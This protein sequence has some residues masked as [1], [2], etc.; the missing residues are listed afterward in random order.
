[1]PV[2]LTRRATVGLLASVLLFGGQ[3]QL[4][5]E[6]SNDRLKQWSALPQGS[7]GLV[8]IIDAHIA[9][10]ALAADK[11]P[12]ATAKW[13]RDLPFVRQYRLAPGPYFIRLPAAPLDGVAV[14]AKEGT[15][16]YVLLAAESVPSISGS[17]PGTVIRIEA[18]SGA[19]PAYVGKWLEKAYLSGFTEAYETIFL[20]NPGKVLLVSTEP[21]WSAPPP[22]PPPKN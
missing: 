5:A 9:S 8:F 2:S 7:S 20:D 10:F 13:R 16:T 15:L 18:S 12:L 1:M 11:L 19:V 3:V 6:D 22:P 21:P 17:K 14:Q 4:Q